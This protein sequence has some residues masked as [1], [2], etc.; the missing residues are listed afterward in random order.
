LREVIRHYRQ[1]LQEEHHAKKAQGIDILFRS[2][3]DR[4]ALGEAWQ[5]QVLR[6]T[7]REAEV[8]LRSCAGLKLRQGDHVLVS[9][10]GDK[11]FDVARAPLAEVRAIAGGQLSLR[12]LWGQLHESPFAFRHSQARYQPG[13]ECVV[14][15]SLDS[16]SLQIA[17]DALVELEEAG[18]GKPHRLYD[19]V[20]GA[21]SPAPVLQPLAL[22]D[23]DLNSRQQQAVS[24]ALCAPVAAIVGPPGTGKTHTLAAVVR[25]HLAAR[26]NQPR[27][28]LALAPTWAALE[29][30]R[31]RLRDEEQALTLDADTKRER[32]EAKLRRGSGSLVLLSTVYCALKKHAVLSGLGISLLVLDEASQVPMAVALGLDLLIPPAANVL[33]VGDHH[34]LGPVQHADWERDERS[35]V[36]SSHPHISVLEA[37]LPRVP[38]VVL[39][40]SYR[41]RPEVADL[42]G[43]VYEPEGGRLRGLARPPRLRPATGDVWQGV[44]SG[45][46]PIV[47]VEPVGGTDRTSSDVQAAIVQTLVEACLAMGLTSEDLGV[48]VPY[49][50]QIAR[51]L[52][53]CPQLDGQVDTVER[54]QG[55]ERDTVIYATASAMPEYI[56]SV[57]R[58]A[59]DPRRTHV[60]LT[61]ARRLCVVVASTAFL[62]HLS[63]D[64]QVAAAQR[65]LRRLRDDSEILTEAVILGRRVTVRGWPR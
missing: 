41:L 28:V 62:C 37:A 57:E 47:L 61:R 6:C 14:S 30:L 4:V 56:A 64:L 8:Q 16:P 52:D 3:E 7:R 65:V 51:I 10:P 48:I 11:G 60:A 24:L 35:W 59:Y 54:F 1:Y 19:A 40:E 12:W 15:P 2:V 20:F 26:G 45:Q 17:H 25:A 39:E 42:A 22:P 23:L 34:Q 13:D 27:V 18:P 21:I 50:A 29:E 63:R 32:I 9:A 43:A 44:V 58:F 46:W 38:R 36:K 33:L 49:R 53:L 55:A 31:E 5:G